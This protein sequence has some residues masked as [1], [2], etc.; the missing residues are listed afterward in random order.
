MH[1]F[2]ARG[3]R[4]QLR[5]YICDSHVDLV[6]LQETIESSFSLAGL[7]SI[8]GSVS[9]NWRWLPASGHS[10]GILVGAKADTFDIVTF[11]CGI[12]YASL[13][14]AHRDLNKLWDVIF[15]YTPADHSLSPLFLNELFLK[16]KSSNLPL[17][18]GGDFNLL[19]PPSD[20]IT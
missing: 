14:L 7:A 1:G 6:C 13:V 4:N 19:H 8:A 17:L 11:D 10:G 18:I 20:K 15:V 5:D 12:F 16:V 2:G 3:H 9:F